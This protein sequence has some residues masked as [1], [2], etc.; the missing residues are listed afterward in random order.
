[1]ARKSKPYS[2]YYVYAYFAPWN[3]QPIYIGKG[4][5][6][7]LLSHFLCG[8]NHRNKIFAG[9][10]RKAHKLGLELICSPIFT[11]LS[12]ADAIALEVFL[13]KLLGRRD[14]GDGILAN[15]TDGGEGQ[16]GRVQ[17]IEER[18]KRSQSRTGHPVSDETRKK[19][20]QRHKGRKILPE[21]IEK[22]NKKRIGRTPWNKG[23]TTPPEV[24]QKI[25][26]SRRGKRGHQWTA[27]EREAMSIARKGVVPEAALAALRGKPRPPRG[28]MSD[29]TKRAISLAN[30]G[31]PKPHAGVPRSPECIA[32]MLATKKR[33]REAQQLKETVKL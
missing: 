12:E 29:S 9:Y 24:R 1:M 15:M 10:F 16:S 11:G 7:R 20:S 3:G 5:K 26:D 14:K 4:R 18:Q 19:I 25:G 8:N 17:T 21:W 33:N 6:D 13:I 23:L 2:D 32:K 31:K 28:P 30:K 27:E 22:A